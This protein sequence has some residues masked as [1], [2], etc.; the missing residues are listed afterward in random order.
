[1]IVN[2]GIAMAVSLLLGKKISPAADLVNLGGSG[3]YF[4]FILRAEFFY[5]NILAEI[6]P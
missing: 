5:G 6:P 2:P 4:F 1:M 3:E